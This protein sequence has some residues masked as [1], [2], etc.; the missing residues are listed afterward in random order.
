[1]THP[2]KFEQIETKRAIKY[3]RS[4]FVALHRSGDPVDQIL[5][6]RISGGACFTEDVENAFD[7]SLEQRVSRFDPVQKRIGPLP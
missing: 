5:V 7:R 4:A 6:P 3:R 1:V 2:H